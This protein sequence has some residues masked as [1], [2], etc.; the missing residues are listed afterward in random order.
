MDTEQDRIAD[1]IVIKRVR[2][3]LLALGIL[4]IT[5]DLDMFCDILTTKY[6]IKMYDIMY[7]LNDEEV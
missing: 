4:C 1:I 2:L 3:G 6:E 5:Y 7:L